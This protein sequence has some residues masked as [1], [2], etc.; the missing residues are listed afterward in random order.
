MWNGYRICA[1]RQARENKKL[2][3]G[4]FS[5]GVRRALQ[6][7]ALEEGTTIQGLLGEAPDH[8]MCSRGKHPFGER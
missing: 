1:C 7:L 8:L 6:L 5:P 3:G 4:Y 2:V